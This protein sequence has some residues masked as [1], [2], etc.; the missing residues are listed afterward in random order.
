MLKGQGLERPLYLQAQEKEWSPNMTNTS[1][2]LN[3]IQ[4]TPSPVSY[5][6]DKWFYILDILGVPSPS[7]KQN[8]SVNR[9]HLEDMAFKSKPSG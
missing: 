3:C 9:I 4:G 1:L 6:S 2:P 8:T 5:A 7:A